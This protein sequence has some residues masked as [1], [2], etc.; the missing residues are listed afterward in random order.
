MLVGDVSQGIAE[1]ALFAF[2][3]LYLS[4][5]ILRYHGNGFSS[6]LGFCDFFFNN[7]KFWMQNGQNHLGHRGAS[8]LIIPVHLVHGR[9]SFVNAKGMKAKSSLGLSVLC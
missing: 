2:F 9:A 6:C 4:L 1:I 5:R 3:L 8:C 7:Q